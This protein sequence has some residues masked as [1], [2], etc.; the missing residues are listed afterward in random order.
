MGIRQRNRRAYFKLIKAQS[1]VQDLRELLGQG[2]LPLQV[3]SR[4]AVSL[5]GQSSQKAV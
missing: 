1:E 2:L 5:T 3:L 4:V